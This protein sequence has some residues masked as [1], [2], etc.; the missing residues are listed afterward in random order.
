MKSKKCI[1]IIMLSVCNVFF[2]VGST[3]LRGQMISST[4]SLSDQTLLFEMMTKGPGCLPLMLLSRVSWW[5]SFSFYVVRCLFCVR[6]F[7]GL[8]TL[9]NLNF[10][11]CFLSAVCSS[12]NLVCICSR[13]FRLPFFHC[14]II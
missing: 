12:I 13:Q 10:N 11:A 4:F 9:I 1:L 6:M 7:C 3:F 5:S 8:L 14:R 2:I